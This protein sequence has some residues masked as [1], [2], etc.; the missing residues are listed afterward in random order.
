MN[1]FAILSVLLLSSITSAQQFVL[2]GNVSDKTNSARLIYANIRILGASTGTTSSIEGTYELRLRP[3]KYMLAASYIGYMTD[4]LSVNVTSD[5]KVNFK[6]EPLP[7]RMSEI[8]VIPGV[9]PALEIIRKAIAA[10]RIRNEILNS[11]E[12]RSYTKGLI[13]TTKELSS[14][15][16]KFDLS[17]TSKDTS[18]LKIT[19]M[20]ENS[21]R[22]YFKKPDK[23]KDEIIARKQS[24]NTP[25]TVNTLT[26]GRIIQNF[27]SDDILFLNRKL[28]SPITDGAIDYYDFY[29]E[30][31]L[32]MDKQNVFRIR[33]QPI[34]RNDPGF[35]GKIFIADKS[36]ALIKV[37]VDLNSAANTGK[38]FDRINI[39]Q[40][41]AS[42]ELPGEI[43]GREVAM[44]IDYRIF[45]DGNYLGIFKFGFELNTIFYDYKINE[46]IGDDIFGMTIVKV[47][48]DADKKDSTYWKTTQTIPNSLEEKDAYK[49]IDS[50]E[51]VPRTFWDKFN[52]L[53]SSIPL[54]EYLSITGPLGLYSFNRV[55]GHT[56]NFGGDL[57][58]LADKRLNT[59]LNLSYGFSDRRLN[60]EFTS[61]YRIGEYRTGSVSLSAYDN[62]ADLFHESIRY[63]KLTSTLTSLIGK[64]DFRNYYYTKGVSA[65]ISGEVL[66][67]L[68]LSAGYF[69]RTD[70]DAFDNSD[71]SFFNRNKV[72]DQNP[73]IYETRIN[74]FTAGF[75]LDFRNNIEDGYFK[76]RIGSPTSVNI[77]LGGEAQFSN[78]GFLKSSLDFQS[79]RLWL[80][81]ITRTFKSAFMEFSL[82]GFYS[83]GP[84]PYQM[85]YSL[86]GNIESISQSYTMRTL[87]TG[88]VFGDRV[89]VL[90]I[91]HNFSDEFFRLLN[92]TF[93]ADMQ[94]TL[95]A[96]FNAALAAI[97]PGSRE[98][99]PSDL[100]QPITEFKHPFYELGF[101]I[102]HPLFPLRL[103]FTWKL[104]YFG[105]NNFVLG[106]NSA[107]L[108]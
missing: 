94:L 82:T 28:P 49:R 3:G 6:L 67:V 34:D 47:M 93:L 22:S 42:F 99:L 37:D 33:I 103:E 20:I 17:V 85:L 96:H 65:V 107:L 87:K 7:V 54:N 44:P 16:S 1:R 31:E 106:L 18:K 29:L 50:I 95:T 8:T 4:T 75:T 89:A 84:V 91:M 64:Y 36:F 72:P 70:N 19:G 9:N 5:A 53:S 69:N 61:L 98:I 105:H 92:L 56:L 90:S 55:E 40:Q 14:K 51:S 48:P 41:F 58:D 81:G 21:S 25:S 26:G 15:D 62:L 88:E 12:F 59:G 57:S 46:P 77:N 60:T 100:P 39:F 13:K 43:T 102:G 35:T 2:R 27:Y 30:D 80:Y 78:S 73:R 45:A 52:L 108:F 68:Q 32:A 63:N 23:Y 86:P 76:R 97:S 101:G 83:D 104:N 66:P 10:K 79:Y 38:L 71:F 24:A 11:Y 74:A